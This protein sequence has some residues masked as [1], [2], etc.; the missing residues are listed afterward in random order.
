MKRAA[1]DGARRSRSISPIGAAENISLP[2]VR[3]SYG[4]TP[5]ASRAMPLERSIK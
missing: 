4:L 2:L 5:G 1:E 3:L